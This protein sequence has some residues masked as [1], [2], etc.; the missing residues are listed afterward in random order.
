MT[1]N[2]ILCNY[3]FVA[4]LL[5][6]SC[7]QKSK[8]VKDNSE[9][10]TEEKVGAKTSEVFA[11]SHNSNNSLDWNGIYQGTIPCADCEGIKTKI[12][13]SKNGTY[14]RSMEYLGKSDKPSTDVGSIKW[15]E[16]GSKI[17]LSSDSGTSQKYQVGENILFQ[18]DKDGNR[19]TGDLADKYKL[20]KNYSDSNLEN[21]TWVLTEMMGQAINTNSDEKKITLTFSSADGVLSGYNGCNQFSGGYEL[22]SGNRYKS[23]PFANTLMACEN[24]DKAN[25]YMG[26]IDQADNYTIADGILNI[27]KGRMATMAKFEV[28]E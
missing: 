27:N 28:K 24:M 20:M 19:I 6:I 14:K 23:G 15:Y 4:S 2:R 25:K 11:D 16:N 5:L 13:L 18:L 10:Q 21:K 1:L 7:G 26:I 8:H 12:T 17:I 3:I 22:M 9:P